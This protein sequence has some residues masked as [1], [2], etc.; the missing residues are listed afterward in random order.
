VYLTAL[1]R[2]PSLRCC[3]LVVMPG[4]VP[5]IHVFLKAWMAGTSPAMT[6]EMSTN[7]VAKH[8]PKC[9]STVARQR[10]VTTMTTAQTTIHHHLFDTA[11]GRCGVAWSAR[12]LVAVQLP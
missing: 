1:R 6:A 9:I 10:K 12:G 7:R 3:C 4:L 11:I 8:R 5:G 2:G